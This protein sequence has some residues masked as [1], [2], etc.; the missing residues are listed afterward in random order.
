MEKQITTVYVL[1]EDIKDF[2]LD[3]WVELEWIPEG[4]LDKKRA[5]LYTPEEHAAVQGYRWVKAT[6]FKFDENKHYWAKITLKNQEPYFCEVH[7]IGPIDKNPFLTGNRTGHHFKDKGHWEEI[8]ILDISA[9]SKA[10]DKGDNGWISVEDRL[11][12]EQT[13]LLF[14][15]TYDVVMYGFISEGSWY[16][17]YNGIFCSLDSKVV[18]HWQPL[19]PKP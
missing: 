7:L 2:Y 18:T 6:D 12:E 13:N 9:L 17:V 10:E 15:S 16:E 8:E 4:Y 3:K 14:Y 19:P 11:P 1:T 5:Y